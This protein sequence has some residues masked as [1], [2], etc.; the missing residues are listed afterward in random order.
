MGVGVG[1]G[2]CLY[3]HPLI[4]TVG[5]Y[6]ILY[7]QHYICMYIKQVVQQLAA[8][9]PGAKILVVLH[10]QH[11]RLHLLEKRDRA[12]VERWLQDGILYVTPWGMND[13]WF[14][15]FIFL[16]DPVCDALGDE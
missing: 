4:E 13:D 12:L 10:S 16:L 15:F 2:V 5:L 1:V 8:L 6:D 7:S 11:V 3:T 14:F 9:R